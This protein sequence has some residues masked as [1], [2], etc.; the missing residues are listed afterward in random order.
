MFT[1]NRYTIDEKLPSN[2]V[3]EYRNSYDFMVMIK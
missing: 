2:E 1:S 3:S